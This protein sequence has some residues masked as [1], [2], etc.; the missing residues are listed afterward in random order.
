MPPQ[1]LDFLR[2][3]HGAA[4]APLGPV[5]APR[6]HGEYAIITHSSSCS[7]TCLRSSHIPRT[8]EGIGPNAAILLFHFLTDCAP[9][10]L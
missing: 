4:V 6:D 8:A 5:H 3:Y 7:F 9:G 1:G 2:E 10:S